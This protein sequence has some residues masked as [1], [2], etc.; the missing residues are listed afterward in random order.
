MKLCDHQH[1]QQHQ[2]LCILLIKHFSF[3]HFTVWQILLYSLIFTP[4]FKKNNAKWTSSVC[5]N[6]KIFFNLRG[7]RNN[8]NFLQS[9]M[10]SNFNYIYPRTARLYC[11]NEFG[12]LVRMW[13]TQDP[14]IYRLTSA[15]NL[16]ICHLMYY[17]H[18]A[19]L[20]DLLISQTEGMTSSS[21]SSLLATVSTAFTGIGYLLRKK[22]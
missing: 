3:K 15:S 17:L 19:N 21:L 20:F 9:Q 10:K 13:Q 2:G 1:H 22:K 12:Y 11:Q 16:Q 4:S 18:A 5:L 7:S 8:E 6:T 14:L